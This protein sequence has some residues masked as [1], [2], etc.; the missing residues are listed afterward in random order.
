MAGTVVAINSTWDANTANATQYREA[1]VQGLFGAPKFALSELKG[2]DASQPKAGTAASGPSVVYIT[3]VCHGTSDTFTGDQDNPVFVAGAVNKATF[4]G[5][6]VHFLACNTA[7]LLGR[8]IADPG[9]GGAKAFFGYSGL[10]TWPDDGDSQYA[11]TFFDCDAEIDRALA[12]GATAGTA[13]RQTLSLYANKIAF[14][15]SMGDPTSLRLA[16]L[17]E[18]NRSILCGPLVDN[19]YGSSGATL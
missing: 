7:A 1:F 16:A 19:E 10:F 12:A 11:D 18:T 17:L 4:G 8:N 3:G 6:I 5:K 15:K 2:A 14:L 9:I 13:M